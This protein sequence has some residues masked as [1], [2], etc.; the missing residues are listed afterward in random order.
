MA[1]QRFGILSPT[2]GLKTDFPTLILPSGYESESEN[3]QVRWGEIHRCRMRNTVFTTAITG[4]ADYAGGTTY[5]ANDIVEYNSKLWQAKKSTTGNTPAEGEFWT[6]ER[7][8]ISSSNKIIKYHLFTNNSGVATLFAFCTKGIYKW[9]STLQYWQPWWAHGTTLATT[10]T[11]WSVCS[12]NGSMY[13]TNNLAL[14]SG[15]GVLTGSDTT[16]F[17]PIGSGSGVLYDTGKYVTRAS[18]VI[19]FENYLFLG[20]TTED[21]TT[22]P[23]RL[24]WCSNGDATDWNTAGTGDCGFMDVEGPDFLTGAGKYQGF[25]VAFKEKSYHKIWLDTGDLV[26]NRAA[27]SREI[28]CAAPDSIVNGHSGELYFFAS[29][30]T[31]REIEFG[32]MSS[33]IDKTLKQIPTTQVKLIQGFRDD[34]YQEVWWSIP[35]GSTATSNNKIITYDGNPRQPIWGTRSYGVPAFANYPVGASQANLTWAD[36]T[37]TTWEAIGELAWD[38]VKSVVGYLQLIGCD[39]SGN[40][41]VLHQ[42]NTDAGSAFTGY[43]VLANDLTG[44]QALLDRKRLLWLTLYFNNGQIDDTVGVYLKRDHEPDWQTVKSALSIYGRNKI[45]STR[46]PVDYQA[47]HYQLKISGTNP[48]EFIGAIFEYQPVGVR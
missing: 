8:A 38:D 7:P 22:C 28:G 33:T 46:I 9:N 37:T 11:T 27:M 45:F 4:A 24:R 25:L 42:G 48:F 18:F 34:E 32:E 5:S 26:F 16:L 15:G 41:Y 47:S 12:F 20:N 23:H 21:S 19:D 10:A 13:A 14:A 40:T 30:K 1:L 29:D 31:L 43:F 35:Y 44:G 3:V 36:M 6:A 17:S 39:T 2:Q